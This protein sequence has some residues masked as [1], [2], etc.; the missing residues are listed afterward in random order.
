[1]K[2][3]ADFKAIWLRTLIICLLIGLVCTSIYLIFNFLFVFVIVIGLSAL[4]QKPIQLIEQNFGVN[5]TLAVSICLLMLILITTVSLSLMLFYLIDIFDS[6][7]IQFP[8]YLQVVV[9]QFKIWMNDFVKN[10]LSNLEL[11]FNRVDYD[12][13]GNLTKLIDSLYQLIVTASYK[14][15]N[16]FIPFISD[17]IIHTIE[18]TSNTIIVIILTILLSKDWDIYQQKLSNCI[19][20]KIIQKGHQFLQHF[21]SIS[22]RYLKAQLIVTSLTTVVLIIVFFL[23]KID[24]AFTLGIAFGLIDFIPIIGVG[25]LLWPWIIYCLVTGQFIIAIELS[26]IYLI[27]V[28]V[29]QFLEPKLV[30]EQIGMSALFVISIGYLCFLLFGLLGILL[31]PMMLI[32][33]QSIKLSQLDQLILDYIRYGKHLY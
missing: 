13:T 6:I 26:I 1:M 33:I 18:L 31:T 4:L 7:I 25:L 17:T 15:A 5:R 12:L 29:R 11:L 8:I 21:I 16:H 9:E 22:W 19:P 28:G 30:S 10:T 27:I 32:T 14:L 2:L 3:I 20:G 23:L 24:G